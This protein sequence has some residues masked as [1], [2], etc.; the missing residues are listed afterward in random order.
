MLVSNFYILHHCCD[1]G[2][3]HYELVSAEQGVHVV[4]ESTVV[5]AVTQFHNLISSL[6]NF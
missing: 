2:A 6:G 4:H 3:Q 5:T 1:T